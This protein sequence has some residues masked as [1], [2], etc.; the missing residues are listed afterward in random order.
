MQKKYS[1]KELHV[2]LLSV[3]QSKDL[4]DARAPQLFEK[5]GGGDWPSVL[6]GG[7]AEAMRFG[8]F[9][10]GKVIVDKKGIVRAINPVDLEASLESIFE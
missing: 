4:Y 10:Y 6:I 9:G 2:V 7:F 1:S 5:Y 8:D 3:D